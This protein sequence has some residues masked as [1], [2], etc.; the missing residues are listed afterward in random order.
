MKQQQRPIGYSCSFLSSNE[1]VS[2]RAQS[3]LFSEVFAGRRHVYGKASLLV[4]QRRMK[5]LGE[6]MFGNARRDRNAK[7]VCDSGISTPP[8][9]AR[10]SS[11]LTVTRCKGSSGHVVG[12]DFIRGDI[13]IHKEEDEG[14][15]EAMHEEERGKDASGRMN[16]RKSESVLKGQGDIA[17]AVQRKRGRRRQGQTSGSAQRRSTG[18]RTPPRTVE[19]V[20]AVTF[21]QAY[22]NSPSSLVVCTAC[23]RSDYSDRATNM[24]L[25]AAYTHPAYSKT[26]K[27]GQ[28]VRV[29][30][31]RSSLWTPKGSSI[32]EEEALT[33]MSPC[34][35]RAFVAKKR[36]RL[37]K[38]MDVM[39]LGDPMCVNGCSFGLTYLGA[40]KVYGLT[41]EIYDPSDPMKRK[42]VR[43]SVAKLLRRKLPKILITPVMRQTET[44]T[45]TELRPKLRPRLRGSSQGWKPFH[46]IVFCSFDRTRK[47]LSEKNR[48]KED[49][50]EQLKQEAL[51]YLQVR[52]RN[53]GCW[54]KHTINMRKTKQQKQEGYSELCPCILQDIQVNCSNISSMERRKLEPDLRQHF[55]MSMDDSKTAYYH[56]RRLFDSEDYKSNEDQEHEDS[57]HDGGKSNEENPGSREQ[58]DWKGPWWKNTQTM[59]EDEM[60]FF[61][62]DLR[63]IFDTL[64]W[65]AGAMTNHDVDT[66]YSIMATMLLKLYVINDMMHALSPTRDRMVRL[67]LQLFADQ[68][69]DLYSWILC[70]CTGP[71]DHTRTCTD[72]L[73]KRTP[74]GKRVRLRK[75][76]IKDKHLLNGEAEQEGPPYDSEWRDQVRK[77]PSSLVRPY[78][79]LYPHGRRFVW[80]GELPSIG[81]LFSLTDLWNKHRPSAASAGCLINHVVLCKT[82]PKRCQIRSLSTVIEENKDDSASLIYLVLDIVFTHLM[83]TYAEVAHRPCWRS[84]SVLRSQFMEFATRDRGEI[85]RWIKQN[86]H[87]VYTAM[88]SHMYFQMQTVPS[89]RAILLKTSWQ[90]ENEVACRRAGEIS[91]AI[92]SDRLAF[93]PRGLDSLMVT[94]KEFVNARDLAG[95]DRK[96]LDQFG[97]RPHYMAKGTKEYEQSGFRTRPRYCPHPPKVRQM[98]YPHVLEGYRKRLHMAG[99]HDVDADNLR[100]GMTNQDVFALVDILNGESLIKCRDFQTKLRKGKFWERL[101]TDIV[102]HISGKCAYVLNLET[103]SKMEALSDPKEREKLEKSMISEVSSYASSVFS[104]TECDGIL[105]GNYIRAIKAVARH[106]AKEAK[107]VMNLNWLIPLGVSLGTI[108]YLQFL[109]YAYVYHDLPDNRLKNDVPYLVDRQYQKPKSTKKKTKTAAKASRKRAKTS[110]DKNFNDQKEEE[111]EQQSI[112]EEEEGQGYVPPTCY[113]TMRVPYE[114]W[115][116][117][118]FVKYRTEE[119]QQHNKHEEELWFCGMVRDEEMR[120]TMRAYAEL[121]EER[122]PPLSIPRAYEY[123]LDDEE[124]YAEEDV[125]EEIGW[126]R[127][128]VFSTLGRKPTIGE[129]DVAIICMFFHFYE[130]SDFF[131]TVKLT[132]SVAQNQ[133]RALR[134]R[135]MMLPYQE[136]PGDI[137]VKR[138][139]G[140]GRIFDP[141]VAGPEDITSMYSKGEIAAYDLMRGMKR[142]LKGT[143]RFCDKRPMEVDMV[144]TA[145]RIGK[146]WYVVCVICGSLT[147]WRKESYCELGPTCGCHAAP[148]RPP[149]KYP[150]AFVALTNARD[151]ALRRTLM[152]N[153]M[154]LNG[155]I[156]CGYCNELIIP[157]KEVNIRVWDDC[158]DDVDNNNNNNNDEEHEDEDENSFSKGKESSEE[159]TCAVWLD[160]EMRMQLRQQKEARLIGVEKLAKTNSCRIT[161]MPLC[162]DHLKHIAWSIKRHKIYSKKR[163]LEDL[164]TIMQNKMKRRVSSRFARAT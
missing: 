74:W 151:M 133:I 161:V 24:G 45:E 114:S 118:H 70:A 20:G 140:C 94:Y 159:E 40:S 29:P 99:M 152:D 26:R 13:P 76:L 81:H 146:T 73:R 97:I 7:S 135:M 91:R 89:L 111:E 58:G 56:W 37:P 80:S 3:T 57:F 92:L 101:Q 115:M 163:F 53:Q 144:G 21:N 77:N 27:H 162:K 5:H 141:L 123:Y 129:M 83:G 8:G 59:D 30:S 108:A 32:R 4:E 16:L 64:E 75:G 155:W 66:G 119:T 131:R 25:A 47:I 38:E 136:T 125:S 147:I 87:V 9:N 48:D 143:T 55:G 22:T 84:R 12:P 160:A 156:Y 154:L 82:Q 86:Q 65:T 68:M 142:C 35:S 122:G 130:H 90:L 36:V 33:S 52:L 145:A 2:P 157:G 102:K 120:T 31:R 49:P 43:Y 63:Y 51:A 62:L 78:D 14:A 112:Y 150:M 39:A 79:Q 67:L 134:C 69:L 109:Y 100:D 117:Y 103:W 17:H 72:P 164:E 28:T 105:S 15:K 34:T 61:N 153:G 128:R 113:G 149:S 98:I 85:V 19:Y 132:P 93:G 54:I 124:E 88:R 126:R 148:I 44:E 116:D 121:K 18:R 1:P 138:F 71:T 50:I 41:S 42:T 6:R 158:R 23:N 139:C 106:G 46:T 96:I 11:L 104:V 60:A 127:Q 137:G 10:Y 95:I 107:G 110:T